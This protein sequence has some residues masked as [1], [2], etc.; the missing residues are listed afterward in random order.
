MT[1]PSCDVTR[2][3]WAQGAWP[4]HPGYYC[5]CMSSLPPFGAIEPDSVTAGVAVAPAKPIRSWPGRSDVEP[6]DA[7]TD[8]VALARITETSGIV[9]RSTAPSPALEAGPEPASG[10]DWLDEVEE[11][12]TEDA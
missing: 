5:V 6:G 10:D 2:I 1:P 4:A 12:E 11:D 9:P 3:C 8:L 7:T